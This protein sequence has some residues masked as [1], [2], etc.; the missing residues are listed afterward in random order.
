MKNTDNELGACQALLSS[1]STRIDG[2]ITIKLEINP[3]DRELVNKLMN[4]YLSD[5]KLFTVAFIR[6]D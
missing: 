3:E 4:S 2:S 1:I 6:M 5:Q